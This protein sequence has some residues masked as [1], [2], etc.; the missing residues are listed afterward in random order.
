[1][2]KYILMLGY[3]YIF[4]CIAT[5]LLVTITSNPQQSLESI[6][7]YSTLPFLLFVCSML[8]VIVGSVGFYKNQVWGKL[9]L[10]INY[11]ISIPVF[12]FLCYMTGVILYFTGSGG[13]PRQLNLVEI[14][15][16]ASIWLETALV[17]FLI[18]SLI[19]YKTK[20]TPRK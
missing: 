18:G 3:L 16:I 6:M 7:E 4:L 1:M 11:I 5:V 2:K 9:V 10:L 13:T 8:A 19:V 12:V 17:V 20:T 15:Q 14:A